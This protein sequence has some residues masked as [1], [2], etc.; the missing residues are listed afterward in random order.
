MHLDNS[1]H[2]CCWIVG[3]GDF[4]PYGFAPKSNDLIVAAD[5]GSVH[6]KQTLFKPDV[7]IGDCDSSACPTEGAEIIRL[8]AEKDDTDMLAA[9]RL[10]LVRGFPCFRIYGGTGGRMDHT[11][12]NLQILNFLTK[13]D[14]RGLLVGSDIT[15]TA[16]TDGALLFDEAS[17]GLL[18]VFAQGGTA[19]GV[20]LEGLKYPLTNATISSYCPLGVSNEFTGVPARVSVGFGTLL[21]SYVHTA[22]EA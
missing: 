4:S 12:A 3:A 22:K 20:N 5:G 13:H 6:L 21:I 8:P 10:G 19:Y 15:F 18:S 7:V 14:A 2:S 1:S 11:L 9:I 16:I 17:V